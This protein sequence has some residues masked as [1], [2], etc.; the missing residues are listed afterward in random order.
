MLNVS[1]AVF[2]MAL[3]CLLRKDSHGKLKVFLHG[4]LLLCLK[5]LETGIL[6]QGPLIKI[7]ILR[8]IWLL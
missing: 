1:T 7:F 8:A 6:I 2:E 4:N 3:A 5:R